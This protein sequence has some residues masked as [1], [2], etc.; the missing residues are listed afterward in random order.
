MQTIERKFYDLRFKAKSIPPPPNVVIVAV[1]EKSINKY[2]RWPWRREIIYQLLKKIEDGGAAVV[3][4]DMVFSEPY[5]ANP[6][7]DKKIANLIEN[8]DNI[9]TGYF[10]RKQFH[11]APWNRNSLKALKMA[12]LKLV[13][14]SINPDIVQSYRGVE[15]NIPE[16]QGA[17]FNSGFFNF[18]PD[19]DG[20]YRN[21]QLVVSMNGNLYPSLA[22]AAAQDYLDEDAIVETDK[23]GIRSISLAGSSI[24]VTASGGMLLNFYGHQKTFSYISASDVLSGKSTSLKNKIVFVG[25]SELGTGDIKSVP[26]DPTMPGTELSATAIGNLLDKNFLTTP[27]WSIFAEICWLVFTPVILMFLAMKRGVFLWIG[28]AFLTS[29]YLSLDLF[30]FIKQ[31][32]NLETIYPLFSLSISFVS[33]QAYRTVVIDKKARRIKTAFSS[34]LSPDVVNIVTD[35][36]DKLSLGGE[37]R[38]LT[39]MFS[40]I[41][42][43]TTISEGLKPAD[44]VK[45]LN[46]ILGPMTDIILA[47]HGMLDKYIGDAIMSLYNVPLDNPMHADDAVSSAIKMLDKLERLNKSR[48]AAQ[49]PHIAVGIGINTGDAVV[50]NM[51]TDVRFDYTAIGDT[52]NLASR[53]E[54]LNKFYGTNLIL[55]QS[56]KDALHN[57]YPIA[58]LDNVKVKGRNRA[59]R[60]YTIFA[61]TM[62]DKERFIALF[63]KGI[64]LYAAKKF[65]DAGNRFS[66]A[67]RIMQGKFVDI[68]L[69]RCSDLIKEPPPDDWTA[70]KVFTSK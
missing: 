67:S 65:E 19:K 26:T 53:L 20:V 39:C 24:P 64:E 60:I 32:I 51:G 25:V 29:S 8:S 23:D 18:I 21:A 49:R 10:F 59:I 4:L 61:N 14:G 56:T 5:W 68:Y 58:K 63:E 30:C 9:T 69:K 27:A 22:L 62:V 45:L 31:N 48:D 40:D 36:P 54:G 46:R 66:D 50:G 57:N 28:A 17:S 35:D 41:R 33:A 42:G 16:I 47:N 44:L 34:Y 3:A 13:K 55:S 12:R 43:F 2:G 38:F 52:I 11:L 7:V 70:V 37:K 1:D 15:P 6:K